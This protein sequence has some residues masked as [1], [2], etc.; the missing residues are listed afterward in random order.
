MPETRFLFQRNILLSQKETET[1]QL[2]AGAG[3]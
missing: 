2:G 3:A 1:M